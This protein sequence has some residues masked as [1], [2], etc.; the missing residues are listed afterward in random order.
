MRTGARD[1]VN[2]ER[3][4]WCEIKAGLRLIAEYDPDFLKRYQRS[5]LTKVMNSALQISG[6]PM[7]N[8]QLF[9]SRS[10]SLRIEVE[11]GFQDSF[12]QFFDSVQCGEAACGTALKKRIRV[13]VGDV[14]R[15][16]LFRDT[17]ALEV[18]LDAGVHAVQSTPLIGRSGTLLGVISTHWCSPSQM[19]GSDF[20]PLDVLAQHTANWMEERASV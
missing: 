2:T 8:I 17:A 18:L 13:A 16:P 20:L 5:M 6:A 15:S 14:K 1:A 9:D 11:H 4:R 10:N 3:N 19:N 7:G 12:L